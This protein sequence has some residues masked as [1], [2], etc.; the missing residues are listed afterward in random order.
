MTA[1]KKNLNKE[2]I[3]L[4]SGQTSTITTPKLYVELTG[5]HSLAVILN[6]C[7]FWSNKSKSQDGWFF[8][9]Y[10]DWFEEIHMPERTLRRRFDKLEERGWISTKVKKANGL[11]T[12]H[13]TVHMDEII[14]AISNMLDVDCPNRPLC[15]DGVND[16]QNTCTKSAPTGHFGRSEPATLAVS[17]IYTDDN[18][19]MITTTNCKSSSSFF[20]SETLDK[21]LL[22]QKLVADKRSDEEFMANV[23][24]HIDNFSDLNFSRI[25]RAQGVLKLLKKLKT[26]NII[27]YAK[28][29]EPKESPKA[30]APQQLKSP[31]SPEELELVGQYK[32]AKKMEA[33]GAPIDVHMPKA[34]AKEALAII[35]RM[36]AMEGNE[37][38]PEKTVRS[39]SLLSVSSLVSHLV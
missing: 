22:Q 8:K 30:T 20:F 39:G 35:T 29:N 11:N 25:V 23:I 4:F 24:K 1:P 7:V 33:Y 12:K 31:F 14:G 3:A 21:T 26:Q 34:K 6:Q 16:E 18:L 27:F 9:E 28:G 37:C 15:P 5:N 17:T 10:E 36:K 38:L 2:I 13:I 32:H 19:H